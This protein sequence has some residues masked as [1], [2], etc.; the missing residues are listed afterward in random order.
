MARTKFDV[1][2]DG[3]VER[4]RRAPAM[5]LDIAAFV[6]T[7]W[8]GIFGHVWNAERDAFDLFADDRQSRLAVGQFGGDRGDF[9]DF[10]QDSGQQELSAA[11]N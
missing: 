11:S 8:D 6:A 1:I 7:Q 5:L 9:G 4:A 10:A 2:L 3:E